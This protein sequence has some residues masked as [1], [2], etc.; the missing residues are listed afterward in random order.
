[1]PAIPLWSDSNSTLLSSVFIVPPGRAVLLFASG[2][3]DER[4][5]TS[6][7]QF[8]GP[9][10][11]CVERVVFGVDA[12]AVPASRDGCA[13]VVDGSLPSAAMKA[14]EQ[15]QTCSLP[16]MLEP[17]RNIGVI[18][19]PGT[20]RLR[21]NDATAIGTAQVFAEWFDFDA[22]APQAYGAFFS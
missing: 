12:P 11:V 7:S 14:F 17:C 3:L 16:W 9:Q 22:I 13:C 4:V 8:K 10:A 2:L 20:Y 21:L 18:G 5:R 15:V 1:M 6:A 19:I